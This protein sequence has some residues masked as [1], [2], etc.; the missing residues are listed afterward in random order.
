M[1]PFD[2]EPTKAE[3]EYL[4]KLSFE[5]TALLHE[6]EHE[7]RN[8]NHHEVPMKYRLMELPI[9]LKSKYL[10]FNKYFMMQNF[11]PS[12][13]EYIKLYKWFDSFIKV[14]FGV[15]NELPLSYP[16]N[17]IPEIADYLQKSRKTLDS[18]IYGNE[19]AKD[20][21]SEIIAQWM[22][23]PSARTGIIALEGPAGT[24]KTTL[25]R[26]AVANT[27]KRPF[28]QISLGGANEG[29]FLAGSNI[30]YEG[31]THGEIISILHQAK[32]MN[33]VIYFDEL[34]KISNT[35]HGREIVN[36]LI[37]ITDY[38]QNNHYKDKYV[39]IPVDLS[40]CLFIFSYN[41]REHVNPILLDR[42]KIIQMNGYKT[43]DK[44]KICRDYLLPDI[45]KNINWDISLEVA[46]EILKELIQGY[47]PEESG[48]RDIKHILEKICMKINYLRFINPETIKE[49]FKDDKKLGLTSKLIKM[50]LKDVVDKT[51]DSKVPFMYI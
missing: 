33:P 41:N 12:S 11:E 10:V 29:S 43:D 42:M 7:L 48:V 30:V 14:P 6:I 44:I 9:D 19:I 50:C 18:Y 25:V 15:Y 20:S 40:Q 16:K 26:H 47:N 1:N 31:S 38:T 28:F 24:G 5:K 49:Y 3:L 2:A 27:L 45:Q 32:C 39:D 8:Y 21:I 13:S 17:T 34:D 22:T 35:N 46:D 23:N 37:H 36:L 4:K 51:K